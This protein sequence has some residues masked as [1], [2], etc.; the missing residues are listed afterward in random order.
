MELAPGY[1]AITVLI[2]KCCS[3]AVHRCAI[4]SS[5]VQ[6]NNHLRAKI[7]NH[8]NWDLAIGLQSF[9]GKVFGLRLDLIFGS[10]DCIYVLCILVV[11]HCCKHRQQEEH[12]HHDINN[13]EHANWARVR[14]AWQHDAWEIA[15]SD[16]L[17]QAAQTGHKIREIL[18]AFLGFFEQ[19]RACRCKECHQSEAQ[20]KHVENSR[21]RLQNEDELAQHVIGIEHGHRHPQVRAHAKGARF[22]ME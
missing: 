6:N 19:C 10:Y 16:E 4:R 21:G 17:K 12:H 14:V 11:D 2:S 13:E 1:E 8:R 3:L 5:D 18:L 22:I 15:Q 7:L 9:E 20:D